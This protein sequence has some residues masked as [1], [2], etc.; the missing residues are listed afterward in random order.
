MQRASLNRHN[1][2]DKNISKAWNRI[3][4]YWYKQWRHDSFIW[5]QE[6]CQLHKSKLWTSSKNLQRNK[7]RQKERREYNNSSRIRR[8][9]EYDFS[10]KTWQCRLSNDINSTFDQ[11]KSRHL[12]RRRRSERTRVGIIHKHKI[13]SYYENYFMQQKSDNDNSQRTQRKLHHENFIKRYLF[14]KD[15]SFQRN[16]KVYKFKRIQLKKNDNDQR[17]LEKI[18]RYNHISNSENGIQILFNNNNILSVFQLLTKASIL[19][20]RN[21]RTTNDRIKYCD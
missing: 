8:F 7:S 12:E 5:Q 15:I 21:N 3:R 13:N 11:I 2:N 17:K 6:R 4:L 18:R 16:H 20:I 9:I 1:K 10:K 19:K 14:K